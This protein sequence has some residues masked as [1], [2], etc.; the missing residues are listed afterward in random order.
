[1]ALYLAWRLEAGKLNYNRI[2]SVASLKQFQEEVDG[3]LAA[4]G[5]IVKDDG[6][7]TKEGE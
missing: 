1:M 7:V 5:Y 6:T 4:D 3:I 2:F